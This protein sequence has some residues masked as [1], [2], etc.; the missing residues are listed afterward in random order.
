MPKQTHTSLLP[1]TLALGSAALTILAL[2]APAQ[3]RP[4]AEIVGDADRGSEQFEAT[5][6]ECHGPAAT[7]PTLRGIIGREVASVQSFYG[8]SEALK[9]KKPL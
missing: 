4:K 3:T 8:Y 9:S 7:A 2:N 6:A 1:T 5:C